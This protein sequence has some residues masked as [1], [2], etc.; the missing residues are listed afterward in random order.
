[1]PVHLNSA[2]RVR[3]AHLTL[4]PVGRQHVRKTYVHSYLPGRRVIEVDAGEAADTIRDQM[5]KW[6]WNTFFHAP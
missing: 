3:D 4:A 6:C 5:V 2:D 1:M